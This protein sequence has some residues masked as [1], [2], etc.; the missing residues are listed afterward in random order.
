MKVFL[1]YLFLFVT[2]GIAY[3]TI[4]LM[5]RGYSYLSMFFVGGVCFLICG[6]LNEICSW[7]ILLWKQMFLCALM[8]TMV[9]YIV[10]MVLNV[11]LG[12][13]IWDYS[14]MPLNLHGQI[15]VPFMIAWYFLS[16]VGIVL[17]DYLRYWVF[18]EEK[19]HYT[20]WR[21]RDA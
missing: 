20:L 18:R 9:E 13:G 21:K 8:I 19:P 2:G 12:L 4:E 5:F 6:S 3:C 7:D 11:K 1:K 15:C 17:D 10:G 16:A 14:N